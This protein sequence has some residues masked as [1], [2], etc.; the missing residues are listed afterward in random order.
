MLLL[1]LTYQPLGLTV[2]TGLDGFAIFGALL[3]QELDFWSGLAHIL[4]LGPD[5]GLV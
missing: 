4:N 5:L 3:N 1:L 2:Q